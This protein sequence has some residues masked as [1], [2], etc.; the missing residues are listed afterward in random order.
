MAASSRPAR[1]LTRATLAVLCALASGCASSS[2]PRHPASLSDA[3]REAK[4][5]AEQQKP[6][7]AQTPAPESSEPE[8]EPSVDALDGGSGGGLGGASA[9][10]AR[11]HFGLTVGG[12]ALGGGKL[13]GFGSFGLQVGAYA[14]EHWRFDLEG[15]VQDVQFSDESH[16]GESFKDG[17]ALACDVSGR[18][19]LTHANTFLGIYP[20]AGLRAGKMFWFYAN[21]L[22][23]VDDEG[24]RTVDNDALG[25]IA[26][27]AG[28][29]A[30]LVQL[31][32]VQL[33]VR[34]VAGWQ[35]YHWMTRE[36]FSNDLI[37]NTGFGEVKV[38]A[39]YLF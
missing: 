20:I 23:V 35:L 31:R 6:L 14:G 4:K 1:L 18:W 15:V 3:A 13:D 19:Y 39:A 38:E 25:F 11:S 27:Y 30:G 10:D 22:T 32:H 29:G 7:V 12:G 5:P 34:G 17:V 9:R 28:V 2:P 16:L 36:G 8:P 37:R 26:P 21:P 24:V 33:G